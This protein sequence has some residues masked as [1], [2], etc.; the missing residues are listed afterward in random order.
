MDTRLHLVLGPTGVG[1]TARSVELA[2]LLSCPV[3]V[4]DRIQCHP[5]LTVGSGRP[6]EEELKGTRR[7]YLNHR[8]LTEG[9]INAAECVDALTATLAR[10]SHSDVIL[11]G[12]SISMLRELTR[13][14]DWYAGRSLTAECWLEGDPGR[15]EAQVERRVQRMLGYGEPGRSLVDELADL[16]PIEVVRPYVASV[17]GYQEVLEICERQGLNPTML[18]GLTGR[19]W[20]YQFVQEVLAAHL[21]YSCQQRQEMAATLQALTERGAEVTLCE[22]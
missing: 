1:K 16:W 6:A 4:L 9:I 17:V 10:T 15:Y 19:L 20:R 3:I 7:V 12:G 5:E 2:H 8:P 13:R 14:T 18:R 22:I 11:E 21:A